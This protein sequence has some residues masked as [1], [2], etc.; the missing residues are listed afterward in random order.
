MAYTIEISINILKHSNISDIETSLFYIADKYN[1]DRFYKISETDGTQKIPRYHSITVVSFLK[2][3]IQ[4]LLNFIKEIKKHKY[5]NIECIYEDD[6]KTKLIFAT[7]YYLQTI[8]KA[9]RIDYTLF[10]RIRSYS[11]DETLLLQE[12]RV[13]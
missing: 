3:Q 7:N 9:N 2:N 12:V 5:Y 1:Y 6:I 4:V 8:D 13:F 10:K 11:E